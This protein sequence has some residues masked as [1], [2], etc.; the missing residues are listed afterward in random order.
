MKNK[1][2]SS[3]PRRDRQALQKRR[4]QALKLYQKGQTQ[5]QIA[6]QLKVSF[7][8]VS[9]W[10]ETYRQQGLK[11]LQSKGRPGPRPRL[12]DSK[13]RKLKQAILKG[14]KAQ[15]YTTD[16]WT[17]QRLTALI[18]KLA[19]TSYHPG[20]VWKIVVSLGFSCQKPQKRAKER[21]EQAIK[22]WLHKTWPRIKRGRPNPAFP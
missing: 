18:K 5:Y 16:L 1:H 13:R 17:L 4:F 6:K 12:T 8:G 3:L 19:R 2:I 21:D 7:E 11:G 20:H 9:N 14:P 22:N 10:V 15:G